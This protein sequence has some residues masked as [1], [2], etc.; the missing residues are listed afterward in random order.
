MNERQVA[1]ILS[2]F[3]GAYPNQAI[4]DS[5]ADAWA[6]ALASTDFHFAETA[7]RDWILTEKWWPSISEITGAIARLMRDDVHVAAERRRPNL[8]GVR[9]DGSSWID[10][11]QGPEP[12]P[13]CNPWLR[14]LYE[15]GDLH[16]R[17]PDPPKGFIMP[18]R[19]RPL[20]TGDQTVTRGRENIMK[21]VRGGYIDG[22]LEDG[23]TLE[24]AQRSWDE[25]GAKVAVG[26]V[27]RAVI[28]SAAEPGPKPIE[29]FEPEVLG[30]PTEEGP[31]DDVFASEVAGS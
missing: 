2:V 30:M 15:E 7:A 12:C 28:G 4:D 3:H 27:P 10:R 21:L 25:R 11:G 16:G 20:F 13:E 24:Q 29:N 17:H 31:S 1:Q 6:V 8:T 23:F 18:P 5:V 19:C 22:K 14:T 26:V 9:C